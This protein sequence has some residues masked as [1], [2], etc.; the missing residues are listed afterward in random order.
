MTEE[1]KEKKRGSCVIQRTYFLTV[2]TALY[3]APLS[4]EG[5][6][7]AATKGRT[8]EC[9]IKVSSFLLISF[10]LSLCF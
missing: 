10:F 2:C 5:A 6:A 3:V 1:E 7:A 8:D 4:K 9:I